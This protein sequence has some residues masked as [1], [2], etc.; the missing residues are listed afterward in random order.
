MTTT[1]DYKVYNPTLKKYGVAQPGQ[2]IHYDPMFG[3]VTGYQGYVGPQN[4]TP[5]KNIMFNSMGQADPLFEQSNYLAR[6][7]IEPQ[8]AGA[9]ATLKYLN[10]FNNTGQQ[11]LQNTGGPQ[12]EVQRQIGALARLGALRNAE[13]QGK[14]SSSRASLEGAAMN[15]YRTLTQEDEDRRLKADAANTLN[16]YRNALTGNV[17]KEYNSMTKYQQGYLN[18]L[19]DKAKTKAN[20][21][22]TA[23]ANY[24]L[25]G[26]K[27]G[28]SRDDVLAGLLARGKTSDTALAY[29]DDIFGNEKAG[30]K[31]PMTWGQNKSIMDWLDKTQKE[32]TDNG[33]DPN[34]ADAYMQLSQSLAGRQSDPYQYKY[35]QKYAEEQLQN[36]INS[37]FNLPNDVLRNKVLNEIYSKYYPKGS[38]GINSMLQQLVWPQGNQQYMSP[39]TNAIANGGI[40]N[41]MFR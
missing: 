15:K 1:K 31:P 27:N 11:A 2:T 23:D 9:Q 14:V 38:P 26:K 19:D 32:I 17:G 5:S 28:L 29:V 4:A 7:E 10:E 13:L 39:V 34:S 35:G 36:L 20:T 6:K 12:E 24:I 41:N 21:L 3:Y 8:I 37:N 25:N 16:A 33:N 22:T 40:V 30:Y 18:L